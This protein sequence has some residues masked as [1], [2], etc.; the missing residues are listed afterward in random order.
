M[1]KADFGGVFE[2]PVG[3]SPRLKRPH[4]STTIPKLLRR[5]DRGLS[6]SFSRRM[7]WPGFQ[8]LFLSLPVAPM[9]RGRERKAK[10]SMECDGKNSR[11]TACKVEEKRRTHTASS[12]IRVFP[13]YSWPYFL[14]RWV[15]FPFFSFL[16]FMK[17][18]KRGVGFGSVC[19]SSFTYNIISVPLLPQLQVT[20]IY[21]RYN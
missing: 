11:K 3:F 19:A 13:F 21:F 9:L 7:H 17:L 5:S 20:N 18:W 15:F 12:F 4:F 6:F 2:S 10:D 14:R 1:G 16:G 8:T